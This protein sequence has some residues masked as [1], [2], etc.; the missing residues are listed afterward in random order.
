MW[1]FA[2]Q[3]LIK[4]PREAVVM[5]LQIYYP[6]FVLGVVP[7]A[8]GNPYTRREMLICYFFAIHKLYSHAEWEFFPP[9]TTSSSLL[10]VWGKGGPGRP[11]QTCHTT[12][13]NSLIQYSDFS[14]FSSTAKL[15]CRPLDARD[16]RMCYGWMKWRRYLFIIFRITV[17]D[18]EMNSSPRMMLKWAI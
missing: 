11:L 2:N 5:R 13:S 6:V 16:V 12:P 14:D 8:C 18:A 10:P 17:K 9:P 15:F 3:Y 1:G 7:S 4:N